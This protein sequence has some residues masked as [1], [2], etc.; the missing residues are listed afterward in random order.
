MDIKQFED[1]WNVQVEAEK[2]VLLKRADAYAT[3]G[4]RLGN[5]YEGA[6]LNQ[7]T[8]LKYGF[9]LVSKHIIALRDMINKLS[10][11]NIE[12]TEKEAE[13]FS[14]YITDIRNY[15]ILLKALYIELF[16]GKE[17]EWMDNPKLALASLGLLEAMKITICENSPHSF[18]N[19][20]GDD[21][22][23]C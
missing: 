1:I 17:G 6:L 13:R 11:E 12:V 15:S 10:G 7:T 23:A 20:T 16:S 18:L 4:D 8:P 19:G 22:S 21:P 5:F 2:A 3:G 9:N 14:E